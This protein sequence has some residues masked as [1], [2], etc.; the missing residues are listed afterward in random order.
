MSGVPTPVRLLHIALMGI[1]CA[2]LGF[3]ALVV[4]AYA[5]VYTT[6]D[7]TAELPAD[8]AI[9]FGAAVY[10]QN[11]PGP[12]IKRRV[13]GAVNLYKKG[14]VKR[15]IMSGGKGSG[16][17]TSEA[18]VMS[19]L[20]MDNGVRAGDITIEDQSHSTWE[21]I[22]HTRNLTQDCESVVAIS[23]QYHLARIELLAWRQGWSELDTVPAEDRPPEESEQRSITREILAYLYY[24]MFVDYVMPDL[25]ARAS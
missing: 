22:A 4:F 14:D 13:E 16:V 20:A 18:E 21:N 19:T 12:A 1:V 7:G 17:R 5:M 6:F 3:L 11:L 8:C 10:G 23:D 24:M 9:V 25:P 15:L 2:V